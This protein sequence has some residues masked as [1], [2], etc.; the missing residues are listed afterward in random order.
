[1]TALQTCRQCLFLK[2]LPLTEDDGN[3]VK[4]ACCVR[5][6]PSVDVGM[7]ASAAFRVIDYPDVWTCGDG[8]DGVTLISYSQGL[9]DSPA[10]P[11]GPEGPV[12]PV[13]PMGPAGGMALLATLTASAS[14]SLS[15]TTHL[16]STYDF[17]MIQLD[18]LIP[19]VGATLNM[20]IS[21]DG[22]S[23]WKNTDYVEWPLID[24]SQIPLSIGDVDTASSSNVGVTGVIHFYNPSKSDRKKVIQS[25]GLTNYI[26]SSA[27]LFPVFGWWDG[28][29]D[30]ING[31]R[32]I[33]ST[34]NIAS[35]KIR[36]YGVPT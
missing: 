22:G 34:G 12:G 23:T 1:M 5:N 14:A 6:A 20:Q 25:F 35:G 30:A 32:F 4:K 36:I 31:L 21:T 13:G 16:T 2:S 9:T 27:A 18:T 8:A 17:Y 10:G 24:G 26:G 7:G 29:N 28:G 15:D 19:S 11:V 33:F 3:T